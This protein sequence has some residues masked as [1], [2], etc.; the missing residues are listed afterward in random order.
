MDLLFAIWLETFSCDPISQ[1]AINLK[2]GDGIKGWTPLKDRQVDK[3]TQHFIVFSNTF[4][5]SCNENIYLHW[6][7]TS[8]FMVFLPSLSKAAL[9]CCVLSQL[10]VCV[11][12]YFT[13]VKLH[14]GGYLACII[15]HRC[16][17]FFFYHGISEAGLCSGCQ[18]EISFLCVFN[19]KGS[20]HCV[21]PVV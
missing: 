3:S 10:S 1:R 7:H 13:K 6:I 11:L 19:L 18:Y 16:R 20:E 15:G 9:L 2:L 14:W 17:W 8:F 5:D 21:W 4:S 12:I